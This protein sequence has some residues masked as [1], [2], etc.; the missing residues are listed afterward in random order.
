MC[1]LS[2]RPLNFVALR[3]PGEGAHSSAYAG[4]FLPTVG[5]EKCLAIVDDFIS[6]GATIM[7][8]EDVLAALNQR[9]LLKYIIVS[10]VEGDRYKRNPGKP[11]LINLGPKG[12]RE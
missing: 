11:I 5:K 7:A 6:T 1:T 3:K 4:K 10:Y 2:K 12:W 9:H 8:I